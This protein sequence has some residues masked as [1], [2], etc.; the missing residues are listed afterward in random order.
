VR[1]VLTYLLQLGVTDEQ[2]EQ[3]QGGSVYVAHSRGAIQT[4]RRR[5][6]STN[7]SP[8]FVLVTVAR[9]RLF[10]ARYNVEFWPAS[11]S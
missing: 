3:C 2:V 9:R 8:V 6:A 10:N 4:G 5:R 11:V 7:R 1:P